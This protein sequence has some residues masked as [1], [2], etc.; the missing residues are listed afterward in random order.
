MKIFNLMEV[1]LCKSIQELSENMI[2]PNSM[3]ILEELS[4]K[5]PLKPGMKVLDLGCGNGLT[6]IFLAKSLGFKFSL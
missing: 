6:S 3:M 5:I 1:T 2:V 4:Q